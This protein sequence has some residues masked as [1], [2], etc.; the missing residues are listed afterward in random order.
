M[1]NEWL[2]MNK[3]HGWDKMDVAVTANAEK[4]PNLEVNLAGLRERA[5]RARN[6]FAQQ[7]ALQAAKQEVTKE[8]Q[9]VIQ[10][11][12]ALVKFLREGLKAYLGKRSEKLIEFGVQ[13]FRGITRKSA[14]KRQASEMSA[15]ATLTPDSVK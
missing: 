12:D 11:G 13:P 6:L 3:V 7:A 5:Q 14:G 4:V 8:L 15:P 1:A 2:Y 10:E 9:Q